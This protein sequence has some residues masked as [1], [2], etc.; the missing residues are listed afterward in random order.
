[1]IE[2]NAIAK[3]FG[4]VQAVD[5]VS[6]SARDGEIT[7]LLG[8]NGAGKST[9]LR[10]LSTVIRPD[11]GTALI[12]GHD[13]AQAAMQVRER[14]GILP[15]AGG[16]YPN[17]T[18]RENVR[19]YAR[20][21]GISEVD[22]ERNMQALIEQLDLRDFVDRR[23][24]GFSQG[25]KLKTSLARALIHR[26]R[27]VILDEPTSG[28]DVA[29]VRSLRELLRG[30]KASGCCVLFSSHVMQEVSALCDDMVIIA[31]GRVVAAGS[32]DEIRR[33]MNTDDLEDAFVRAVGEPVA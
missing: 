14:L 11:S 21:R 32:P 20:L 7:G 23:A 2:V 27:N 1:M 19:Y 26:P 18:A 9:T 17:L 28:L 16:L 15:H 25:Q 4:E 24:K 5:Q 10:I 6:F 33:K 31:H 8:P 3:R 30:L 13:C 29:S 22:F 12:D